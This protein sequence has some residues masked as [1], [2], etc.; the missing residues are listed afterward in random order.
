MRSI[1]A[2]H[3]A[4]HKDA[5]AVTQQLCFL[6]RATC[7]R[8]RTFV[9]ACVHACLC[10][11]VHSCGVRRGT[12]IRQPQLVTHIW[13]PPPTP[14]TNLHRMRGQDDGA[15]ALVCAHHVPQLLPAH[16]VKATAQCGFVCVGV[17][18]RECVRGGVCKSVCVRVCVGACRIAGCVRE[19]MRGMG[20][21]AWG[22][23][24]GVCVGGG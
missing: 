23:V 12:P 24:R 13:L 14:P 5:D 19:C 4:V 15:A 10:V 1:Q 21:C 9:L 6:Q 3:L 16:G 18:V 22:C 7:L 17:C 8:A 20:V 11:C 2:H